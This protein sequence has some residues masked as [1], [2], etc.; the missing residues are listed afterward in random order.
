[1]RRSSWITLWAIVAGG[2]CARPPQADPFVVP[3]AQFY[4]AVDTIVVTPVSLPEGVEASD[5]V[6]TW[7]EDLIEATLRGAG[8]TVVPVEEY[9]D[10]WTGISEAAGGFFDPFTGERDEPR[11]EAGVTELFDELKQ[12]FSPDAILYPEMWIVEA[13]TSGGY[14]RWGGTAQQ[15]G[16][17]AMSIVLALSLAVVLQDME[18]AELY[19][20]VWG[21]EV[22][23]VYDRQA[24]DFV[25]VPSEYLFADLERNLTAI[26]KILDPLINRPAQSTEPVPPLQHR[27]LR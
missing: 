20:N 1:M 4:Q 24:G 6:L 25:P 17:N 9:V 11:Y 2:A 23:E 14:A 18:G 10:I 27:R 12:R 3:Q 19:A 5:S 7:F 22:L 21:L 13:L 8:F 26:T 15:V 16:T